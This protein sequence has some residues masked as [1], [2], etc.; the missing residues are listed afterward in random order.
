[1]E[2]LTMSKTIEA[3][4]EDNVIED[5]RFPFLPEPKKGFFLRNKEGIAMYSMG[6]ATGLAAAIGVW[7]YQ[8]RVRTKLLEDLKFGIR[9]AR[10][11][12]EYPDASKILSE[13]DKSIEIIAAEYVIGNNAE[14][15]NIISEKFV[16]KGLNKKEHAQWVFA[17]RALTDLA[18]V[19]QV[20][21]HV[22][23]N[24]KPKED[25]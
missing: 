1:M 25:K 5:S 24:E 21:F 18:Q 6:L 22:A 7:F 23:K 14:L 13:N 11:I 20:K 15:Q 16:S 3:L 8:R 2:E 9:A 19:V 4:M 10:T 12:M 17:L